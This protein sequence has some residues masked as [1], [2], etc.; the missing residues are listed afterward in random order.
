[1]ALLSED[2]APV[3]L[4]RYWK[5]PRRG[6]WGPRC[7]PSRGT[8]IRQVGLIGGEILPARDHLGEGKDWCGLLPGLILFRLVVPPL[9]P[10]VVG[11][12]PI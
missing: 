6:Y 9:Q 7:V 2:P 11:L 8:R 4:T 5:T 12:Y 1:M 3:A 10:G